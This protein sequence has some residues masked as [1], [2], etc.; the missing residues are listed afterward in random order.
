MEDNEIRLMYCKKHKEWFSQNCSNCM[1][2]ETERDA[3]I[4]AVKIADNRIEALEDLLVC[5]RVGKHPT[6]KLFTKLDKSA[7]DWK[8]LKS[9]TFKAEGR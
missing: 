2:D 5:Y 4:G 3:W 8:S 6:E 7:K 9:G 1:A